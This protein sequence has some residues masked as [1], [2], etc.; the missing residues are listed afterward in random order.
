[1]RM[2]G[3]SLP[4]P[5]PFLAVPGEPPVLWTRWVESFNT[6]I[7]A[8]GLSDEQLTGKRKKAL[9]VHCL[10]TEGQRV[11]AALGSPTSNIA[12]KPFCG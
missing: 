2:A 9:L 1:M 5:D 12:G 4:P 8:L 6:Y 10:G 11:L 7:D 3:F